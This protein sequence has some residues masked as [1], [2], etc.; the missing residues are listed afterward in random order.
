MANVL[1]SS[2]SL[3]KVAGWEILDQDQKCEFI[4]CWDNRGIYSIGRRK[5]GSQG[6]FS[7][8]TGDYNVD[9]S[10]WVNNDLSALQEANELYEENY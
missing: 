7:D 1:V 4:I 8:V 2:M 9:Y 3:Q 5:E 10:T 6:D